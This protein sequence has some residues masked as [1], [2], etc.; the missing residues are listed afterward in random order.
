MIYPAKYF[1]D[2]FNAG[3]LLSGKNGE[4]E[5]EW[6]GTDKNW[7]YLTWIEDGLSGDELAESISFDR[8]G[9]RHD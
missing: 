8:Y 9:Q 4:G 5:L 1:T 7:K 3:L 6:I 2:H